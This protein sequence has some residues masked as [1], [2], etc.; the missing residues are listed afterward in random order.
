MN[1]KQFV[2]NQAIDKKKNSIKYLIHGFTSFFPP[3]PSIFPFALTGYSYW[4]SCNSGIVELCMTNL[5]RWSI[6]VFRFYTTRYFYVSLNMKMCP[7]R[8]EGSY[9]CWSNLGGNRSVIEALP[10]HCFYFN[11]AFQLNMNIDA[12]GQTSSL[13]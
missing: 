7:K 11:P 9:K 13:A 5:K 10:K 1:R 4:I 2:S 3:F 6:F 12:C 8:K